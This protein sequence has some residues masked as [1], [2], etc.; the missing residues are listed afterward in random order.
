[1]GEGGKRKRGSEAAR[2]SRARQTDG[3]ITERD[4]QR[5]RQRQREAYIFSSSLFTLCEKD[6]AVFDLNSRMSADNLETQVR[7]KKELFVRKKFVR[8]KFFLKVKGQ[9]KICPS[10]KCSKCS[11]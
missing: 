5:Q 7:C 11:V 1:M 9:K 3:N 8:K 6:F 10:V 2:D 4:R